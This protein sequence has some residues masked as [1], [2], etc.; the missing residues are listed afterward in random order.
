MNERGERNSSVDVE[1]AS[2]SS[3]FDSVIF[4]SSFIDKVRYYTQTG[5]TDI[6]LTSNGEEV[7]RALG[8]R[9][10]GPGKI[11]DPSHLKHAFVSPRTRARKTF[12]LLFESCPTGTP[13]YSLEDGVREWDYGVA[14]GKVTK[15]IKAKLGQDWDIWTK[16]CPEGE[17]PQE[18]TDRCDAMIKK[19]VDLTS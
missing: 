4:Y 2:S 7:V 5:L 9:I 14:E 15:D 8:K 11:L 18:M 12:E 3:E 13:Q 1:A 16:G 17:S 19:I 10:A 6:P